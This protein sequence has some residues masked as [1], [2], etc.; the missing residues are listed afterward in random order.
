MVDNNCDVRFSRDGC[1]VQDQV[2]RKI[3]AKGFK[4]GH[5]FPLHFSVSN[6]VSLASIVVNQKNEIWH[7]R[8][9]HP[10]SVVLSHLI[11][12]G[13]LG[14]KDK[15]SS[16][17]SIDCSACK[18]GKIKPLSFPSYGSRAENYFD[19]I[20]SA[21]GALLLLYLMPIINTLSHSLMVTIN[22]LGFIFFVLNLTYFLSSKHL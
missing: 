9:G 18:L 6:F 10:N 12:S 7:K 19:I 14:N 3:L 1:I 20:H 16:Q 8:I 2:S 22:I 11:N 21:C 5:S 15:F 4:V 13:L 17:F